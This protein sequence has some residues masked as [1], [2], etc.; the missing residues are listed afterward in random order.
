[1]AA[2]LPIAWRVLSLGMADYFAGAQPQR[3]L[4]WRSDHAEA[5]LAAAQAE[6]DPDR[7]RDYAVR[8]LR[9][10]PLQGAAYRVLAAR[11]PTADARAQL[12]DIA[13]ARAPRDIPSLAWLLDHALA[14]RRHAAAMDQL[15]QMLRIEP[16]SIVALFPAVEHLASQPDA[17]SH[18][19]ALLG[20]SPP[21]RERVLVGLAQRTANPAAVSGVFEQLRTS[22]GGLSERE[23][24][25][26]LD[27]LFKAREWGW[28]YLFWATQLPAEKRERLG[29]VFDG[30]FEWAPTNLGF[31][32]RMGRVPGATIDRSAIDGITGTSA[33]R[34]SFDYQRVAF[35]HVSQ[36]LAL[37]A[38]RY[39]LEGRARTE[40]LQ[41]SRGLA[42]SVACA[43]GGKP[44]ASTSAFSGN[45]AWRAFTLDLEIPAEACGGQWL[46]LQ[47]PARIPSEQYIGGTIWFDDLRMLRIP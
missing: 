29:N 1:L 9:A 45:H 7:A 18:L 32:W 22:D 2:L 39:R 41:T 8:S 11:A 37:P 13:A 14:E 33:L 20:R 24:G 3:A 15:D 36:L 25:A 19:T 38:G 21:W 35:D 42:W 30:G 43:E 46:R 28:A 17:Q 6:T 34:V 4:Q 27:R 12:Y 23:L 5:L 44:I 10:N 47:L 40:N 16:G 26:W 31:D